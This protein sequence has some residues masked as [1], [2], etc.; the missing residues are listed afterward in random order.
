MR[1]SRPSPS[2]RALGGALG[3][4]LALTLAACGGD[5]SDGNG[6]AE[7]A[8]D[9]A[10]DCPERTD[11]DRTPDAEAN[12]NTPLIFGTGGNATSLDPIFASDGE[13][14]RMSR[15]VYDTLLD[16][17]CTEMVPGLAEHWEHNDEG[18]EWTFHLREG[19]VFHDGVELDASAVCAN[20]ERWNGFEG[21]YQTPRTY[22]W[23]AMFG[24]YGDDSNYAGCEADGLTATIRVKEYSADY[25]GAFSMAT[26][27]IVSPASLAQISDDEISDPS[28]I[29]AYTQEAGVLAGTGPFQVAGWNH[30]EAEI[31]L[32]RFDEYWGEPAGVKTLVFKTVGDEQARRQALEA[33]DIHG[34]DL[35]SPSDVQPL[36]DAGFQV[37]TRGVFNL[38]YLGIT[39]DS[40]PAF[41]DLQVRQAIAHAI[42]RERIVNS[43][44]PPGAS[45]ATQFMPPSLASWNPDVTTY[46]YDTEKASQL[47]ADAGQE[48]MVLD[49]CYPTDVVR[50]YMPSVGDIF[51]IFSA[52][53]EE[54][55][56]VVEPRPITWA[57][58][59]PEVNGGGC[60][61]NLLGWTGDFDSGFNFLGT[62]FDGFDAAWGF[63]DEAIFS[64]LEN[65]RT[66][67]DADERDQ[68]LSEANALLMDFLPGVPV[69]HSPPSIA[70]APNVYPPDTSPLTQEQF[71]QMYFAED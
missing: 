29:P 4:A 69:S 47:L 15:Q 2:R 70:F 54:A 11:G 51:D 18:T 42:D 3:A 56:F 13:T 45:V 7:T 64:V 34:Y 44:L 24:G 28:E 63:E 23:N 17:E 62:W 25:P 30:S 59:I 26:F 37:P 5:D 31:R 8:E 67:P 66:S 41:E 16:H 27:A 6:P 61:L 68:Y 36:L 49:F 58:Y 20:F 10:F 50:P 38:L 43:I 46:E 65:A 19:V 48:G 40:D 22:Y 32:E 60:G 21:A 33:G 35:V 12:E 1:T 39:I 71:S 14:F 9:F 55:G 57:D 53:L 52:N